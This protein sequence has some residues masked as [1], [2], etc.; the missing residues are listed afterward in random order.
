MNTAWLSTSKCHSFHSFLFLFVVF[1]LPLPSL[2]ASFFGK[3]TLPSLTSKEI[4]I[5][6][7]T[8]DP[9]KNLDPHNPASHLAKIL[10]PRAPETDNHTFVRNYIVSTLK[11]LNWHIDEDQFTDVTPIGQKRFTNV[12]ATKDP[13]ASR[14]VVL[15][16]H[17]DSK[18][19]PTYPHNQFVGATDSA[20]PCAMMLDLAETLN[21]LLESRMKQF[22]DGLE[23]DDDIADMTLQLVFFDGEEAFVDWTDTDSIYGA[24]HLAEKWSTTYIQPHNKRR[25]MGLHA[26]ELSTIEHLILL[27]LLGAPQP[28]I[29]SYYLDTAW[30]FDA[31][32]SVERRLGDSGAFTYDKEKGMA[33]GSW[34][35]YFRPRTGKTSNYGYVGDDH[36]PFLRRGVS[37]LHIIAEPFP[38]VWHTLQDDI[39]ALDLPT[40]RRW[41]LIL[42]VFMC[43]YLHLRPGD[44]ESRSPSKHRERSDSELA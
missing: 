28:L 4:S 23:D 38:H 12:V 29:R 25:L 15:S 21:P 11:A 10:I 33:P 9:L 7:T 16:A 26:T 1:S 42:R 18:Y 3:R 36:V 13:S 27:D 39:H 22:Q 20:A 41:N 44:L 31:M 14:R 35:S 30:L 43:E 34:R 37:I 19:F 2:Q 17:F 6:T 40:M 24:R 32:V 8:P 5:L